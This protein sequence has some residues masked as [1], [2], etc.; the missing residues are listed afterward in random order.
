MTQNNLG[1]A[2]QK[3][4]EREENPALFEQAIAA[5]EN[6]LKEWTRDRMPMAWGMTLAN[7]GVA[8]RTLADLTA[9]IE[10]AE[11][12]V[13]ELE[14]VSEIFRNASHAHY[15]E[16]SIEELAKARKLA[17]ALTLEK[18]KYAGFVRH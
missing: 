7:L 2:L 11:K 14:A 5:Y 13:E 15:S 12:A 18:G 10:S 1:A 4:G 9:D 17:E 6:A 3:L 8:R 16:L